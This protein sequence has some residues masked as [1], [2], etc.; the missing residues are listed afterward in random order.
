MIRDAEDSNHTL[1][2][3]VV[4]NMSAPLGSGQRFKALV[5]KLK[6]NGV[7]NP[8]ALAAWI[9]RKK[10]GKRRFQQLAAKGR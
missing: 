5:E 1:I 2:A 7:K 10:Y 6:R 4:V 9:G 8:K 3:G